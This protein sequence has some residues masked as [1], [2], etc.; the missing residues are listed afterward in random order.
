MVPAAAADVA[1]DVE[2]QETLGEQYFRKLL[3]QSGTTISKVRRIDV[4]D[5]LELAWVDGKA[6]AFAERLLRSRP[7]LRDEVEEAL[8]SLAGN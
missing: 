4:A 7:E 5:L 2:S 3:S 1:M 8:S 6:Q